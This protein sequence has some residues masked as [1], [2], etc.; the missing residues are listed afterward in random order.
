M[1]KLNPEHVAGHAEA[2]AA[3]LDAGVL[4]EELAEQLTSIVLKAAT[5]A[6]LAAAFADVSDDLAMFWQ[7][8]ADPAAF[9]D[10]MSAHIRERTT[11]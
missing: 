2:Q 7:P 10:T 3:L 6:I 8:G 9:L 11:S 4:G 1:T 5:P